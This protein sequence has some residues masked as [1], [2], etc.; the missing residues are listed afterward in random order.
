MVAAAAV[1][2]SPIL[3][4]QLTTVGIE[5]FSR[6]EKKIRVKYTIGGRF[7][8]GSRYIMRAFL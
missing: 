1:I 8:R 3:Q 5:K 2:L 7:R 6:N 4:I